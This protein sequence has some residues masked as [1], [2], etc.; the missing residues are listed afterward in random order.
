MIYHATGD[1]VLNLVRLTESGALRWSRDH[2]HGSTYRLDL[3]SG[4]RFS[5]HYGGRL[6]L[7]SNEDNLL[8]QWPKYAKG[9]DHRSSV[10]E[11]YEYARYQAEGGDEAIYAISEY[12]GGL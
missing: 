1:I 4:A 6:E 10:E 7:S 5:I 8:V 2:N 9:S 12:L 11:L 3:P